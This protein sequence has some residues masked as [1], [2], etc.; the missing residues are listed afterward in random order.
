MPHHAR[1]GFE[2]LEEIRSCGFVCVRQVFAPTEADVWRR[3]CAR[4]EQS[5]ITENDGIRGLFRTVDE[6]QSL[7]ERLDPI[8]DVSNV[9]AMLATDERLL[10]IVREVLA[11][12]PLLMKDK[13]LFKPPR[14]S[15]YLPHQDQAWWQLCP[16]DGVASVHVAIDDADVDS[17]CVEF[18]PTALDGLLTPRGEMRNLDENEV[19]DLGLR[20]IAVRLAPGD[21]VVF[22]ALVPHQSGPNRSSRPRRSVCFTY[23]AKRYGDLYATQRGQYLRMKHAELAVGS[24]PVKMEEHG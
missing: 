6:E 7:L 4:L 16:A 14:M 10:G 19:A 9:F 15:G 12:E 11:D 21:V 17:G 20:S 8:V 13:L 18:F 3:E 2:L 24:A 22:S 5:T 1:R 23:T